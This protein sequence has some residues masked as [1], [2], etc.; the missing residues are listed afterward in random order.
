[1]PPSPRLHELDFEPRGFD[2]IDCHDADHSVVSL[3]A[4]R[5]RC[6]ATTIVA[7]FNFTP[8][9]A[10]RLPR[11]RGRGG[12]LDR[13]RSTAT[14][15]STAAA[16]WATAAARWR[17][18]CRRTDGRT[19][20]SLTLPPLGGDLP[21]AAPPDDPLTE[22]GEAEAEAEIDAAIEAAMGARGRPL[23]AR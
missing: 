1:M 22:V 3:R 11:R 13:D 2:W 14:P 19:A 18:P 17:W 20:S 8:V 5:A 10:L 9:P 12:G 4:P 16:A 21:E 7:V 6:R 23:A 15:P